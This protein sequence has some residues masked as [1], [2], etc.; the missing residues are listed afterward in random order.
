MLELEGG[1]SFPPP[2]LS[3]PSLFLGGAV[4]GRAAGGYVCVFILQWELRQSVASAPAPAP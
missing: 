1:A 4:R 3:F 2:T